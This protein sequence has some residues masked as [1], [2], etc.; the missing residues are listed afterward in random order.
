MIFPFEYNDIY[1]QTIIAHPSYNFFLTKD[2]NY[3]IFINNSHSGSN[4]SLPLSSISL[5]EI[6]NNRSG[7]NLIYPFIDKTSNGYSISGITSQGYNSTNYGESIT[8]TY[9]SFPEI[10]L[11]FITSTE[12]SVCKS[13][14]NIWNSYKNINYKFN[15]SNFETGSS[16]YVFPREICGSGIRKGSVFATIEKKRKEIAL[17]GSEN[18]S[19]S[20]IVANDIYKDGILRIVDD[21]I[22]G[23]NID[24]SIG[25]EVGYILYDHGVVLFKSSSAEF[26]NRL[27]EVKEIIEIPNASEWCSGSFGSSEY[28][29]YFNWGFFGDP[30]VVDIPEGNIA[31]SLEFQGINKIQNVTMICNLPKRKLN[32]STNPTFVEYGQNLFLTQSTQSTFSENS[33]LKIKNIV[34]S[35]Y[36]IDENFNKETFISHVYIFDENKDVI[37]IAKLANPIIKKENEDRTIKIGFDI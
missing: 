5:N 14:K 21:S 9:L 11:D 10:Y 15:F 2:S 4:N 28:R 19:Y 24:S 30:N 22:T 12:H 6:N 33:K 13:L 20:K 34:S 7:N 37:G 32:N 17:Y 23:T 35:S 36:N 1:R 27:T 18:N 25:Q 3:K 16:I 8:G 26:Y 31:C 29:S